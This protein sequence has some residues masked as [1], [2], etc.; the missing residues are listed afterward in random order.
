LLGDPFLRHLVG[1]GHDRD[2]RGAPFQAGQLAGQ[3]F[4]AGA[5]RVW[6]GYAEPDRVD[7]GER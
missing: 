3:V 5:N 6:R 1:L 2:D 7:L 4:V